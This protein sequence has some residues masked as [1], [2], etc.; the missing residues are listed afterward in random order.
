MKNYSQEI[1]NKEVTPLK[2]PIPLY[3]ST[4][5]KL[6]EAVSD[7]AKIDYI[8]SEW[9][10]LGQETALALRDNIYLFSGAKTFDYVLSCENLLLDENGQ[11]RSYKEFEKLIK[12]NFELRNKTWLQ[13][14][15]NS[16][17]IQATNIVDFE[18]VLS[19]K[20][21]FPFLK[22]VTF[23]DKNVSEICRQLD[24]VVQR[25]DSVFWYTHSPMQHYQCRCR[26][27]PLTEGVETNLG[28]KNII[29][30]NPLFKNPAVTKQIFN[31]EHPYF[32]EV[33]K[34]YKSFA[35]DNF[36]LNIPKL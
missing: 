27:E 30:P 9:G 32:K 6:L 19:R 22:Y 21:T 11:I 3:L 7:G 24:N 16:A 17:Q 12:E 14:E 20:S 31:K 25:T 4:A 10:V 34:E 5:D 18:N 2:L 15:Y 23:Q 13:T 36:G 33:P 35:K 29:K 26:L 28:T 8:N 1:Y